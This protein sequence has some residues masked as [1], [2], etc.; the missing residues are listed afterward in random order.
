MDNRYFKYGCPPLMNDGRFISNYIRSSTFD[1]YVRNLNNIESV[2]DS[3]KI[4]C[5]GKSVI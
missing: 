3:K 4:K 2:D 5:F 1:Q